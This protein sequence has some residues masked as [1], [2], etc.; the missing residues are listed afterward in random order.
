MPGAALSSRTF[1]LPVV[2]VIL[3]AGITLFLLV[4]TL[5]LVM[6]CTLVPVASV[7]VTLLAVALCAA[8]WA[9]GFP[10]GLGCAVLL[11]QE[12]ACS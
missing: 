8:D 1:L 5:I 6:Y 10:L 4:S 12:D 11:H 7:L 9:L 2:A 3:F